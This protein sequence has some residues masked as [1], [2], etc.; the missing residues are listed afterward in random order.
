[1]IHFNFNSF[2]KCHYCLNFNV[3]ILDNIAFS[4]I[5]YA[6]YTKCLQTVIFEHNMLFIMMYIFISYYY[7]TF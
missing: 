3:Q 1:M 7:F 6:D 5:L 2:F 4:D